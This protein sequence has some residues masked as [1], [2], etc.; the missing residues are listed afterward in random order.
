MATTELIQ[1][2]RHLGTSFVPQFGLICDK[3]GSA[4]LADA[5]AFP[6]F[7]TDIGMACSSRQSTTRA[8]H[9][10]RVLYYVPVIGCWLRGNQ[11]G[12]CSLE[13]LDPAEPG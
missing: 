1:V 6:A 10:S 5:L 13:L 8:K 2:G 3:G 11:A 4:T 12:N 7:R 9:P